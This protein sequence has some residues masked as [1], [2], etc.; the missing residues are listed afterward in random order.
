M[1]VLITGAFGY[2]GGR[3]AE[4]MKQHGASVVLSGRRLPPA[5]EWVRKFELRLTELTD[6]AALQKLPLGVDVVLHL[7]S[8]SPA[9]SAA[10]PAAAVAV[11]GLATRSLLAASRAAGVRRFLFASTASVYGPE[12][13]GVV[14][15]QSRIWPVDTYSAAHVVGEAFCQE[16]NRAVGRPFAICMRLANVYGA[17]LE[18]PRRTAPVH[19]DLCRQAATGTQIELATPGTQHRDFVWVEDVAQA[20]RILGGLDDGDVGEPLY[21]VGGGMTL[22][23]AALAARVAERAG[24]RLGRSVPVVKPSGPE[25]PRF[26]Y[27]IARLARHGYTPSDHLDQE[28]D[29]LIDALVGGA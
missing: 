15:E 25:R 22:T 28:T 13:A 26:E 18:D 8:L 20:A 1:R 10:D 21:N 17:A 16:L 14:D 7:A 12:A 2:L 11:S 29:R 5:A 3:I 4:A 27:S 19:N 9:A 6:E 24:R 23:V